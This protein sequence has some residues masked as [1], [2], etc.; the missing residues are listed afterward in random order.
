MARQTE[1][2]E[3]EEAMYQS[4]YKEDEDE[5]YAWP[6]DGTNKFKAGLYSWMD[7]LCGLA[8]RIPAY[9]SRGPSSIPGATTFPEK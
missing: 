2:S 4:D 5:K 8:V 9:R 6:L 3:S 1:I 7:R